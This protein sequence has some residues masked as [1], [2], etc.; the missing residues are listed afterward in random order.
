MNY[1]DCVVWGESV[2]QSISKWVKT[3]RACFN[4][5]WQALT[6]QRSKTFQLWI[7]NPFWGNIKA[8]NCDTTARI[9]WHVC[10][11]SS[12]RPFICDRWVLSAALEGSTFDWAKIKSRSGIRSLRS[13]AWWRPFNLNIQADRRSAV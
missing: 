4:G 12:E 5:D 13:N 1:T 2:C 8:L 3:S 11:P 10:L 7:T 9:R 6:R